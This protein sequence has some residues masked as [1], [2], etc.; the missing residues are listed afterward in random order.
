MLNKEWPLIQIGGAQYRVKFSIASSYKLSTLGFPPGVMG[1][2][3]TE[4]LTTHRQL[5]LDLKLA[6]AGLQ[7]KAPISITGGSSGWETADFTP[8]SLADL[9]D[10]DTAK[11]TELSAAVWTAIKNLTPA[12]TETSPT[13]PA[14]GL[15]MNQTAGQP[16]GDGSGPSGQAPT[17]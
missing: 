9:L 10:D 8:Q 1:S 2:M 11:L 5:E 3:M 15:P 7:R 4:L 13:T 17:V 14:N 6:S 16:T 12:T